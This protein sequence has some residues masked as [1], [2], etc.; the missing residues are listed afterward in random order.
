[1]GG[2]VG[3]VGRTQ[4][5]SDHFDRAWAERVTAT[6]GRPWVT[7]LFS[8]PGRPRFEASLLSVANGVH[9]GELRRW[10]REIREFGKPIDLTVL[11]D[12]DRDWALT[13]AVANGGIPQDSARAW[14]HVRAVFRAEGA[15]N[16][17][18]V[19]APAD[20]SADRVYAPAAGTYDAVLLTLIEYPV[21]KWP[22]P[23]RALA[24]AHAQHPDVPLFVETS[25]AGPERRRIE[26]LRGLGSAIDRA[27][28]V[29]VLIYHEGG[30][31]PVAT[32][33]ER[34]AWSLSASPRLAAAFAGAADR[35]GR[36]RFAV[37]TTRALARAGGTGGGR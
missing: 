37:A 1:L 30:P 18:W 34:A 26:W 19:W 31:A 5:I 36:D 16:A 20:P 13:S 32:P 11:P 15:T 29:T 35:L 9:D 27:S 14:G 12:V 2:P 25:I 21:A 10:A 6:R 8:A 33:A 17:A 4:E 28:Y 7:L 23:R 22:D 24:R 3:L